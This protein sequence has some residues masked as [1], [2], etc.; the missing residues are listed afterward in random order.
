MYASSV[1]GAADPITGPNEGP[2][3]AFA[4]CTAQP[5]VTWDTSIVDP[6]LAVYSSIKFSDAAVT[7][8]PWPSIA[9]S[10]PAKL[11]S[12]ILSATSP[13]TATEHSPVLITTSEE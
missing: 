8:Y 11:I 2:G 13:H 10:P 1:S 6:G 3:Y 12:P 5:W 9:T 7:S 4:P